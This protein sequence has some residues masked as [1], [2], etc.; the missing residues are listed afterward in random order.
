MVGVMSPDA[1]PFFFEGWDST[2]VSARDF[3]L[4]P[5]VPPSIGFYAKKTGHAAT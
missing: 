4:P 5:E 3:S 1:S 2:V